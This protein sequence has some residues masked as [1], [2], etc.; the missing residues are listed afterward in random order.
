MAID[1][2][3]IAELIL[4]H[5]RQQ[6]TSQDV[7]ELQ[8]WLDESHENLSLF[9]SIA[10]EQSL[11]E[12]LHEFHEA[13]KNTWERISTGISNER[14]TARIRRI[15]RSMSAVAAVLLLVAGGI[16]W[17]NKP[18]VNAIA[19]HS[20]PAA[21]LTLDDVKAGDNKATLKLGDGSIMQLTGAQNG[22]L[23]TEKGMQIVKKEDGQLEYRA[24]STINDQ[25]A[26]VSY[27]SIT[28]PRGGQYKVVLSD[29]TKAW[30]NA[31]SSISYPVAFAGPD[32]KVSITGEV[33]FE[34]SKDPRHPFKVNVAGKG[35]IEVLGTQFNVNAYDD[36]ATINTTL[37]EG[38]VRVRSLLSSSSATI[39][40]GQQARI[41][42]A[43]IFSINNH[44]DTSQVMAWKNGQFNFRSADIETLMRQAARWYDVDIVYENE[45]PKDKFSGKINRQVTLGKLLTILEYS[46]VRVR[47]EG[48][49]LFIT[50]K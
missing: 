27:N 38:R 39:S 9:E 6:M 12:Q 33:Y 25:T 31:A 36:E 46:E 20:P 15:Y 18:T 35:E 19:H 32:R 49:R 10:D 22:T 29:G 43:G 21:Q 24:V 16:Y 14:K 41:S 8:Q 28:T 45:K 5:L 44:V 48:R 37:L 34:V 3:R 4:K 23:A 7:E 40:P 2:Q 17:M 26:N 30:L 13:K 47:L 50:H 42:N 11:I 1:S